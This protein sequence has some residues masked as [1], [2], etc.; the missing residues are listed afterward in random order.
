MQTGEAAFTASIPPE[1][2]RRIA[3]QKT[4]EKV[5]IYPYC[6]QYLIGIHNSRQ[7]KYV[8]AAGNSTAV[9]VDDIMKVVGEAR[10]NHS[11]VYPEGA[12]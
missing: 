10:K 4:L 3:G 12:Y 7:R 1:L 2:T 9:D 11:M 6:Q 8:G 5:T